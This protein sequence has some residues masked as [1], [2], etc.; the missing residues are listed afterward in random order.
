MTSDP[1]GSDLSE[2]LGLSLYILSGSG[3]GIPRYG[4]GRK[5]ALITI[6]LEG[7][8]F[9]S[10]YLICLAVSVQLRESVMS[11][12]L[13]KSVFSI[14]KSGSSACVEQV[15]ASKARLGK[16][17]RMPSSWRRETAFTFKQAL[18]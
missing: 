11:P 7:R 13:L 15:D 12:D 4:A 8:A 10:R 18:I 9:R 3:M 17:E 6:D 2:K 14:T 16:R 1:D 5:L